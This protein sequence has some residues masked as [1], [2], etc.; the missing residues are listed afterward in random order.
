[1]QLTISV[2]KYAFLVQSL[3]YSAMLLTPN[4]R[5]LKR[6]TKNRNAL[7]GKLIINS[8]DIVR[9]GIRNLRADNHATYPSGK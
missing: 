3:S 8:N 6:T 4:L 9:S 2:G 7:L 5:C 1:M